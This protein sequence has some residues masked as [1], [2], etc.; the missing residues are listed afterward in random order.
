MSYPDGTRRGDSNAHWF[1]GTS[2]KKLVVAP[3]IPTRNKKLLVARASLQVA[4]RLL[5]LY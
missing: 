2:S 5:G 3:G 4:R 1:S